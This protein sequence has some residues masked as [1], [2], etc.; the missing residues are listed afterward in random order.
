MYK[1]RVVY[2]LG[3]II[4]ERFVMADNAESAKA[5][6]DELNVIK[7]ERVEEA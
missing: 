1:W 6:F 5:Q 7:V 3:S 2:W 4:T